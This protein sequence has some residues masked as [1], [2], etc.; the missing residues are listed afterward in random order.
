M[1]TCAPCGLCDDEGAAA[2]RSFGISSAQQG[3]WLAQK[4]TPEFSNNPTLLW[5][6]SGAVD[7]GLLSAALRTVFGETDAVLV[8]F[9]E[10]AA[11]LRQVIG[12]PGRLTPF[13]IDVGSADD[14]DAAALTALNELVGAP[15]DLA[16]DPLYRVGTVRL[17]PT[18]HL[19]VVIFQHLAA[20]GFS[21]ITM[22]SSRIAEVYTALHD[23]LAVPPPRFGDPAALVDVDDQYRESARFTDD[24]RFWKEYLAGDPTPARLPHPRTGIFESLD[25]DPDRRANP[26]D[27]WAELAGA[28]GMVSRVVTMSGAEADGL[29]R[30]ADRVGVRVSAVQSAA[31]ALFCAR[32]CG[33]DEPLFTMSVRNRRGAAAQTPGLTLNLI[34]IRA[35]VAPAASFAE[36]AQAMAAEQRRVFAHADHHISAIQRCAGTA[37]AVRDPFGVLLNLMPFVAAPDFAG[38]PARLFLGPWGIADELAISLYRDGAQHFQVRMDAPSNLY[39]AAEL[40]WL[41]DDLAGFLRAVVERPDVPVARLSVL[42]SGQT[43]YLL[44]RLNAT[45]VPTPAASVPDLVRRQ[46]DSAIA[47]VSGT[48]ALTYRELVARARGLAAELARRGVGPEALVAVILPRSLDLVVALLAVLEAGGAYVPVDPGYPAERVAAMLGVARPVLVLT[49]SGYAE[50]PGDAYPVVALDDLRALP[51]AGYTADGPVDRLACVM[52]TSGSTG[53]PKGVGVTHRGIVDFVSDRNW[54]A[55]QERVLLRSPHTFDAA[56]YEMWVPLT[57]GGTVVVAPQGDLDTAGLAA[58]VTS[59]RL[60]SVCLPSALLDLLVD[61]DPRCLTGLARVVTGGERVRPATISRA[62]RACPDITFFNVYGPTETTVGATTHVVTAEPA[63]AE[64]PIGRPYDNMRVFVLDQALQPVPPGQPGEL[65]VAGSGV[66]RGYLG[67]PGLTTERFVACPWGPAGGRMYRTGDIVALTPPGALVFL[68]RAD[69]QVKIRGFRIEPGEVEAVLRTHPAVAGAGV[70]TRADPAGGGRQ[71]VAYVA[72]AGDVTIAELRAHVARQL[73]EFMVPAAYGLLDRLPVSANGKL[74]RTALPEPQVASTEYRPPRTRN[75]QVLAR[76]YTELTG[77]DPVGVDDNFFA[78]GGNSLLALRLVNQLRAGLGAEIS[79]G[80]VFD[81]PKVGE[82]ARRLAIGKGGR[83]ALKPVARPE[84]IPLSFAQRRLWFLHRLEPSATYNVPAVFRLAGTLNPAVLATALRDV[85]GRHEALRTL[86][87]ED[88]DGIAYQH[89]IAVDALEAPVTAVSPESVAAAVAESARRIFDLTADLPVRAEVFQVGSEYL[90]MLV[91]HHIAADGESVVPLGRD[92]SIAYAARRAGRAPEWTDLPVQYADYTLW[93]YELMAEASDADS[94]IGR[95]FGYWR[96][97]LAGVRGPLRLPTDRPRPSAPSHRGDVLDFVLEPELRAR[98]TEL[99]GARGGTESMV[100]QAALSV[101]LYHLGGGSDITIG[102]PVAGRTDEA[103]ADLVGLFVNTWVLRVRLSAGL[104]F[105]QALAQVRD[106]ALAAYDNQDA[107][108]DRIVE[109]V[110]PDRSL[111]YHPLCQV[112]FTWQAELPGFD[113]GGVRAEWNLV[114]TGTAKFDLSFT[115]IPESGGGLRGTIEYATDLFDRDTVARIA[116]WYGRVVREV[117]ADPAR[118]IGAIRPFDGVPDVGSTFGF[119]AGVVPEDVAIQGFW[120][121]LC[122]VR[123]VAGGSELGEDVVRDISRD[124]GRVVGRVV[125]ARDSGPLEVVLPRDGA[126]DGGV[127][128]AGDSGSSEIVPPGDG[129]RVAGGVVGAW[130]SGRSE[131][132]LPRDGAGDGGVAGVRDSGPLEIVP[133]GDGGRVA[134]AVVGARDSGLSEIVLPGDGAGAGELRVLGPGLA[135]VPP[136]VAGE[137]YL[138][139]DVARNY[140]GNSGWVARW[141]VADPFGTGG[142]M[143]R[144]GELARC[145]RDGKLEYAG[146][147]DWISAEVEAVLGAHPGV[148]AAAVVEGADRR[149]VGYVVPVRAASAAGGMDVD[150]S[151]DFTAADLRTLAARRLPAH[152]VPSAIVLLDRLPVTAT[153]EPDRAALPDPDEAGGSYRE[154]VSPTERALATIFA[155]VLGL[156]RVGVDDDFFAIG[157]E[158]IRSIQVA[159][160]ARAAGIAINTRQVFE[161]RT[162]AGL[163]AAAGIADPD[164]PARLAELEGGATGWAPLLPVAR[165]ALELG[166]DW[167]DFAQSMLLVLPP[168]ADIAATVTAVLDRHGVLRTRLVT[169]PEPGLVVDPVA[170]AADLIRT[171]EWDGGWTGERWDHLL[172][173]ELEAAAAQLAP[174]SGVMARLVQFRA[175]GAPGR[176]LL[177]LHHLVVDVVSWQILISDLAAAWE[178][179]EPPPATTSARRWAHALVAEAARPGRMAEMSL[180][181][182]ILDGPDP[183]IGTRPLDPAIDLTSTVDSVQVEL[184][185]ADTAALL[186]DLPAAYRC[187][188]ADAMLAALA[189]AVRRWRDTDDDSVLVRVEGHGREEQIVPGADLSRTVG[190]FTSVYPVRLEIPTAPGPGALL[191]SV[192]EQLRAIPDKGIGYG[193]LRYLN[194]ETGPVLAAHPQGQISFNYLG[195][196]PSDTREVAWAPA[197]EGLSAPVAR[198]MPAAS[199]IDVTAAAMDIRGEGRLRVTFGFP[200]GVLSRAEVRELA[201][202]WQQAAAEFARHARSSDAGGLTPSDVPLV[203][204]GQPEIDAWQ[205]EFPGLTDIWPLTPLQSGLLF[206]ASMAEGF[207]PYRVQ[208]VIHLAGRV[209]ADR[210]RAAGQ[211]VLDRHAGLRAGFVTGAT[212]EPVQLVVAGVAVPWQELDLRTLSD[213]VRADALDRFLTDDLHRPSAFDRPPLLRLALV[214]TEPE[215]A[216]LVLTSHHLL[217]DGWC[218][219]IL[220]RELLSHYASG[221]DRLPR[222]R[223]FRSYLSWLAEQDRAVSEQVWVDELDGIDE[224]TLLA[225]RLSARAPEPGIG[226]VDVPLSISA[227]KALALRAAEL[228]VTVNTVVQGAWGLLLTELTGRTDVVFGATVSGRPP[229]IAGVDGIVGMFVNTVPVRVRRAPT[230]TVAEFLT[231]LQARQAALLEHHHIGLAEI[232]HRTGLGVLFDTLVAFESYPMDRIGIDDARAAAG[233]EVTGLRPR[234]GTHYPVTVVATPDPHVRI[235]LQYQRSLLDR[236]TADNIATRFARVLDLLAGAPDRRLAT[237][238]LLTPAEHELL[239]HYNDTAAPHSAST[240]PELVER[241]AAATPDAI[242]VTDGT[243]TSTYRELCTRANWLA[244]K[245]FERGIRPETLTAIALPRSADLVVAMLAVWRAGGAYLPVDP[246]FP[247]ARLEFVL[248]EAQPQLILTDARTVRLLP[249]SDTPRLTLDELYGVSDP[250]EVRAADGGVS[251]HVVAASPAF[252]EFDGVSDPMEVRAA[253]GGGAPAVRRARP[254]NLAYVMYTSGST[255]TPK[256][257]AI[258]HGNVVNGIARLIDGLGV[259]AGWRML[260]GTSIGFDVSVFEMFTT[261]STGGCVE[262]VR[263]VLVLGERQ[264]WSG[265][266]ISTV[267]SAFGEL[268]ERLAG[269]VAAD[270]VVFAG[271]ALS[272]ALAARVRA[273]L[274]SARLINAYGQSESFYATAFAIPANELPP[275]DGN[276]PIGG[277]LGNVRVYVLGPALRPVPPGVVGELYVAGASIGRGYHRAA[278]TSA[279]RFVADPFGPAGSRMYR[280]GDLAK[281]QASQ[282]DS[283]GDG[284]R[285][286]GAQA[287]QSDSI[288]D[289]A[290]AADGQAPQSDSIRHDGVLEYVGR[291]DAQVKIRGYRVE[292][293]EVEAA[294]AEHPAVRQA[295]VVADRTGTVARLIGYAVVGTAVSTEELRKFVA[296]RLPAYLVPAA[297]VIVDRFPLTPSGKLDR[298]ALPAPEFTGTTYHAPRTPDEHALATLFA[299]VLGVERVGIDDDFFA[300]GG[301]SLLATRL[302]GRIRARLAAEVPIRAVFDAPTVARLATRLRTGSRPRPP[303]VR[304]VR[305]QTVPLSFAQRRMWFID[306]FEGPSATY[307]LLLAVRMHGELDTAALGF[308]LRDVV[309]RHE[310][311]RTLIVEDAAGTAAQRVLP[312]AEVPEVFTVRTVSEVELPGAVAA[313]AAYELDL[314]TRVPI[315]AELLRVA[316]DD[317][318]L[319]LVIHHI[320]ADGASAAPLTRDLSHAYAARRAGRAPDWP[321]LPVQYADY[322]LWH[323]ELLGD[324]RDPES[325]LAEQ[326]DYWRRELADVPAPLAL[327]TDRPRPPVASHRG[328]RVHF[329][330]APELMSAVDVVARGSGATAAMVLQSA[331]SVLLH[332]LGAGA[333]ITI[334]SPIAGRTDEAL[335]DVVGFFVNTW[336]L[337]V[338]LGG[339]PRFGE[340][341]DQV[342][343][344]AMAAYENQD[345]P[346]ERLVELLNPERSTAY[347]PLFQ[348]MFAWQNTAPLDLEL[349]GLR[350][351]PEPTPPV[352]AKFD[353]LVNLTPDPAGGA[354]GVLEYATDLFDHG[355]AELIAARYLRVLRQVVADPAIRVGAVELMDPAERDRLVRNDTET[356]LPSVT[357]VDLFGRQVAE[358]PGAVALVCGAAELSYAELGARANLVANALR[359]KGIGPETLVAVA[360]PRTPDLVVALLAVLMTGGAYVPID[361]AYPSRRLEQVL[362]EARPRLILGDGDT[363]A[364]L[365]T[366]DI[367][368]LRLDELRG[369][370]DRPAVSIRP[371]NLAYVMYTSGSTGTPKGVAITHEA[372]INGLLAL[373]SAVGITRRTRMCAGTSINFDVSLFELFTTLCAGGTVELVRDVLE[374]GERESW[375]GGVL[376]TVPSVLSGLYGQLPGRLTVDTVVVAGEALRA[377]LVRDVRAALPGTGLINAYGQSESFYASVF[378]LPESIDTGTA[379]I[380]GPLA[381]MRM[382]VLGPGLA[383]VPP[384]VVGELYVGGLVAR[385]YYGLAGRTAERFVADPFGPAGARMYRT[386]DLAKWSVLQSDSAGHLEYVGRADSQ[387]KVRGF[388]IEPGEIEAVL[389]AHPGVAQAVV[390]AG[391]HPN[392]GSRLIG[393]V[394]ASTADALGDVDLTAGVSAAELRRF[395]ATR[396]PDYMV[397]S[398]FVLLDRLPLTA[399]GKLDRKA[400]PEPDSTA[401][402]YRA[403]ETVEERILAGVYAE[404]LGLGEIGVDDDFFAVGGDSIRSIQVVARARALGIDL[405]P[406]QIFEC[407]TVAALADAVLLDGRTAERPVLPELDQG[408]VGWLPLPPAAHYLLELGGTHNR[409]AMSMVVGLPPDITM[410]GLLASLTAVVERHDILRSR[411][412]IGPDA[413]SVVRRSDAM[414]ESVDA[415]AGRSD[416]VVASPDPI[417]PA[418]PVRPVDRGTAQARDVG[419]VVGSLDPTGPARSTE[420]IDGGAGRLGDGGLVVGPPDSVDVAQLMW[421][422]DWDPAQSW[423]ERVRAEIDTAAGQLDPEAGVMA[424][425]V[426]VRQEDGPGWLALVLHHLVVDGVSWRILLPDLAAAWERVRDGLPVVLPRV[427]TSARRWAHALADAALAPERIAELGMWRSVLDGPDPLIGARRLDPAVDTSST[428]RTIRVELPIPATRALLTALPAAFHGGVDDGLL[429][430]LAVSVCAWRGTGDTEVLLRLEGHGREEQVA[431]GADLSRTVGWLTSMFPVRLAVG[432]IAT[433]DVHAGG[434]AVARLVK[435]VKEQL[436]S[437]PDKGIGYGLLRYL[438]P[439]TAAELAAYPQP[440]L[441]FNYLGQLTAADLPSDA[442]WRAVPGV[443]S[444]SPDPDLPAMSA[445]EIAAAVTDDG[446]GPQ[447]SAV[448]AYATGVLTESR[449]RALTELWCAALT[450]LARYSTRPGAG[451]LTPSDLALVSVGQHEIEAWEREHP[452][453]VDVWPVTATQ[454]GLLFHS[455]LAGD[456]FDAYHMQLVF[457]LSGDV[458][459]ARMRAAGR[460]LLRR[461]PNLRTAFGHDAAGGPVQLVP[462]HVELPWREVDFTDRTEDERTAAFER[463]LDA[464]HADHFDPVVPPLLRMTLVRM[465][466]RRSELVLSVHHALFDGWSLPLLMQDLLRLYGSG[467]DTAR[468]ARVRPYRDFLVWLSGR[469]RADSARAWAAELAGLDEP[470]MLAGGAGQGR[471]AHLEVGLPVDVARKLARRTAELGVTANTVVQGAW[472]IVLGQLTGRGDVVFGATVSGRPPTLAGADT[473]VG[474]FINTVPVRVRYEP[475]QTLAQLLTGLQHRQAV[476]MDH[477]QHGLADIQQ[478]AGL[479]NLFDTL[480][481]FESFPVDR[482]GLTDAH[483]AADVAITGLRSR[484]GTH[485][486]LMVVAD[487]APYLRI[488]L[489]YRVSLFDER[490][491]RGIADRITRVLTQFAADPHLPVSRVDTLDPSERALLRERNDTAVPLPPLTYPELFERQVAATPDAIAVVCGEVQLTYLELDAQAKLLAHW[492]I[493]HGVGPERRVALALPRTARLVVA[494]LAILDAGGAYVPI[495][496][497]YPPDRVR[498]MLLD[499]AP[500]AML[501]D[502]ETASLLPDTDVPYLFIE[503]ADV[504]RVDENRSGTMGGLGLRPENLAYLVYTSGSTGRPKGIATTHRNMV[505]GAIA[506]AALLGG[507][508]APRSLAATS[509]SFDVSV[510]EIFTVLSVGGT[511]EVVRDALA[512]SEFER[513]SGC[514]L[515]GVPSAFEEVLEHA[516]TTI[517]ADTIVLGGEPLTPAMIE[518]TRARIPGVQVVNGYGPTEAFYTT[519]YPVPE[520]IEGVAPGESVPIGRPLANAR[521]YVLD[522][523]LRPVPPGVIGELYIAGAGLARGYLGRPA[524]T[525]ARFIADP[526]AANGRLYRTGDLVRWTRTGD[527]EYAGRVDDQV[528]I[529]GYRIELGEIE[530]AMAAHP[531]VAQAA[532]VAREFAGGKRL[533]GYVVPHAAEPAASTPNGTVSDRTAPQVITPGTAV[534]DGAVPGSAAP[535]GAVSASVGPKGSAPSGVVL[536]GIASDSA[537]LDGTEVRRFVGGLLPDYMVP[538]LVMVID[539]LPLTLNG[540]LD[541]KALPDPDFA[542]ATRYRAPRDRLE[543]S[544][545]GLFGEVLGIDKVG[546]Y[547]D[548]FLL[549]GHSLLATRLI[550][551]IRVELG[552]EL[553]IR[554]VFES[555][556]VAGLAGRW[557]SVAPSRRPRLRRMAEE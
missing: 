557:A 41:C 520:N 460:A 86:V 378:E 244:H 214:R 97:E 102:A 118:A 382:Y 68:G 187:G 250:M 239:S 368:V 297:V 200:R 335:A 523:W 351:E 133:P 322:T 366:G 190:W 33:L 384:G 522:P 261:L 195:S 443:G 56:I 52:F 485:Y 57:H 14:P 314:Y 344:K 405:T 262:V 115:V 286:T 1:T 359:D 514:V 162:V 128:G 95:Q 263:D 246:E 397:P 245:L 208:L 458:D 346:F 374:L 361:P 414:T 233:I 80:A 132:V 135:A 27:T 316:P 481:V 463:L 477:H 232:Q 330:V 248:G 180:W 448:F 32:R 48:T 283:M 484:T 254:D 104:P 103:L 35:K 367:P 541:R 410:E 515:T 236:P 470:T 492:L 235:S 350:I 435:S 338:G 207:D 22:L 89:V 108:F 291:A 23:G 157:G 61:A 487:A 319:M 534:P 369:A 536:H 372:V 424:R 555:P 417:D 116:D 175:T 506:M 476:L 325:L 211:A 431:P 13:A 267:P 331:L 253:D 176:L 300:L 218:L 206:H 434:D 479:G 4:M 152:L 203:D 110:N 171:V 512:L 497:G 129:G 223:D 389:T 453:L 461:Y 347:H 167:A 459:P 72:T 436:L 508:A 315:H 310:S 45:A 159:V 364:T 53:E 299:E 327:P 442:G 446:P 329:T 279:S 88:A 412:V 172:N 278:G 334:G 395:V 46:P 551:R 467:G 428:V 101:L 209:D 490:A 155:D 287:P 90:L 74:D 130:D 554:M 67:R 138:T 198:N 197:P 29:E 340:L 99:A 439:E 376:S 178:G 273:I 406:R 399:N 153:G 6:I 358:T 393:Y 420:R 271:E 36:L 404:V 455:A 227:A 196:L 9:R 390:V 337:R 242:A 125:G 136:G 546:I 96:R 403:P 260:A 301:H 134:G 66:A 553:P 231:R 169:E 419:P 293:A 156:D 284:A 552:V 387:V 63:G 150:I 416:A 426:R 234:T 268:T 222:P 54:R 264:S 106:K 303:L 215:R 8:N 532:V 47:V 444:P 170:N 356:P 501:T 290:Q 149:L 258:T 201:R 471:L 504:S 166:G 16:N 174:A 400:L 402:P 269:R 179:V 76:L 270:A 121:T 385:G 51:S 168:G 212:G 144:T 15:F 255:G 429:A 379:P 44:T 549:G 146:R 230:D 65:Y 59:H 375:T 229:A 336:V 354:S 241:Q 107:P 7:L 247:G 77:A 489:Q 542:A 24:A 111:A 277:P 392:G 473:M 500:V 449:V 495:D 122:D 39:S 93:Q 31:V 43:D 173:S 363:A 452:G 105:E 94:L 349:P 529:R 160:R 531:A 114:P 42:T 526:F 472:A 12:A 345:A 548:F 326:F 343:G 274:P 503:D 64:L 445:L 186:T 432:E 328:G 216:E 220:L 189:V 177:V 521:M 306:R 40:R 11:G 188:A 502:R 462:E 82:L 550:G 228:G 282:S 307:N 276:V 193:L 226:Q 543:R 423:D 62:M 30:L 194:P 496:P 464:D 298:R 161:H 19:L 34:P 85:V 312:A 318:V 163:A 281:W 224:P 5:E 483:A 456:S 137:V 539:A 92:L 219:S 127:A 280:T 181:R 527:L 465:G 26:A 398:A 296:G 183:L 371:R 243:T 50:V 18:R 383:P 339:N 469:D 370:P 158:S 311:L 480:V 396:L 313:L 251:A 2:L 353:L 362:T 430:A 78:L 365:P 441:G 438:N 249:P 275:A 357:V 391:E 538:A 112:M 451:G 513:W 425:F 486:P 309:G 491:A 493:R 259:G 488:V 141:F 478:A 295:V 454:S 510:F 120:R 25:R 332:Q 360:L 305:P 185:A 447:L 113:L 288:G 221:A 71:L 380:G 58:L 422:V 324:E 91:L 217:I 381:N 373:I 285:A 494:I 386:G 3:L 69:E 266:V 355:T 184:P 457:H 466:P 415:D 348:V 28:I 482:S 79:I 252:E 17:A 257:V 289:G 191:K 199:A 317:H 509:V 537:A 407:R 202:L 540:K 342:R 505:N 238:D 544:L 341:L 507:R 304:A 421:C 321:D 70:V 73:P 437:I 474:L 10:D 213:A 84:R 165:Y 535:S 530:A 182:G 55:G 518:R 388:R 109:L 394:V 498:F 37:A 418:P 333:D 20:D 320:A 499:A 545:A 87:A 352:A 292:P 75:E 533:I 524:L 140:R 256:G 98:S 119:H 519:A 401:G 225:A 450:G 123:Q 38:S 516:R 204:V 145:G 413:K 148:A 117:L 210:M 192:K 100:L 139:G 83:P 205:A 323:A 511:A 308:A 81:A 556:T 21:A 517:V 237:F 468:L 302:V 427:A 49:T 294:L 408:G 377:G 409:F 433:D 528:K 475:G 143:Y 547:D 240:I 60:T 126:G 164:R 272:S 151:A 265:G 525:A 124:G 440:Q 131:V 411:L 147:A 142:R 154:P